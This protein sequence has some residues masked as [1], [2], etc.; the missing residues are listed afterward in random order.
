MAAGGAALLT[1]YPRW[2]IIGVAGFSGKNQQRHRDRASCRRYARAHSDPMCGHRSWIWDCDLTAER[3]GDHMLA[4]M[5]W[6]VQPLVK[7][8][9]DAGPRAD[10]AGAFHTSIQAVDLPGRLS[11]SSSARP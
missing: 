3:V 2:Q 4:A 10:E 9:R 5:F 7:E 1:L 8:I 6:S 11:L